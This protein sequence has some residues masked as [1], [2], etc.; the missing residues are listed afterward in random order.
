MAAVCGLPL[1]ADRHVS[2]DYCL[3]A[4]MRCLFANQLH[5]FSAIKFRFRKCALRLAACPTP[6]RV[7]GDTIF[8]VC[9]LH[10][11]IISQIE[12]LVKRFRNKNITYFSPEG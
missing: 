7:G 12:W 8:C 10:I 1:N 2:S 4:L 3:I 6:P 11:S 5:S 9:N